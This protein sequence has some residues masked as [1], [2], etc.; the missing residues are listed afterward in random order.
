MTSRGLVAFFLGFTIAWL[1]SAA[2][3]QSVRPG[4]NEPFRNPDVQ[5]YAGT[6]EGESREVF[7]KRKEIVALVG[8][9]ANDHVADI[10]AGTGLF[11]RLFAQQVGPKGKVYAVDISQKFLD[12]IAKVNQEQ[13]I[14]NV[15]TVLCPP[16]SVSL[17][18]NSIDVA[19]ICDTYHHFEFPYRTMTSLRR[20]LKPDGRVVVIDFHRIPGKSSPWILNHVRAGQEVFEKEIEEAGFRK[21]KEFKEPLK[22]NYLVIFEKRKPNLLYPVIEGYGGVIPLPNATEQPQKGTKVVFDVTAVGEAGKAAPGLERAALL[23]N[24]AATAQLKPSD[25]DIV[26]VLH[27]DAVFAALADA[28]FKNYF[29]RA[30]DNGRLIEQLRRAG[31]TVYVCGQSLERQ[32]LSPSMVRQDVTLITSA[33]VAVVN[34]QAAGYAVITA[35]K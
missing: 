34:R 7:A 22:E 14:T 10:G 13:G 17:P 5:K 25:V 29:G 35:H 4:I 18:P 23:L 32:G 1:P 12:H 9:K 33:L 6:F 11:T 30:N 2:Q 26:I 24:L 28:T 27:G 20:A 15:E 3:E 16:D 31:V 19:F 21:V 8:L